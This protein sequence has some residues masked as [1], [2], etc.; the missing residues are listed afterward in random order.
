MMTRP[1]DLERESNGPIALST[2]DRR[3]LK[4]V[5]DAYLALQTA[6][7][8]DDLPAAQLAAGVLG[9]AASTAQLPD[10]A[11]SV[12]EPL[13]QSLRTDELVARE[14]LSPWPAAFA[15]L[16]DVVQTLLS[17]FGNSSTLSTWPSARWLSTT[18]WTWIQ[19][20]TTIDNAY[21]PGVHLR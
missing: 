16:S 15:G 8:A 17:R 18:R 19:V 6:L 12:W 3:A 4:P 7:A 1:D 5:F 9:S 13:A 11:A 10:E 2:D 20:G 14:G 21:Q